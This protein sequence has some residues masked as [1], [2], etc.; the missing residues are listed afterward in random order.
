MSTFALSGN[1]DKN[2]V[3]II[4]RSELE[5]RM[6]P[7][8]Y[9]PEYLELE[10]SL[11]KANAVPLRKYVRGIAGGATPK[12]DEY[13]KYYAGKDTGIPF[14]R[15]QN[16]STTSIL[17]YDDCKYINK[18]THNGMLKRSK[19]KEGDLLVK[20]TG[21]GRMAIASVAPKGFVGNINQHIAVIKTDDEKT[22]KVLAAWLNTDMAEKLA[23]RRSTR[24]TRPA[25]DYPALLSIPVI[26]DEKI[27]ELMN[28][29][30]LQMKQKQQQAQELLES[31]DAYLLNELGITLPQTDDLLTNR[32]FTVKFSEVTGGRLDPK[33]Y[34]FDSKKLK[35]SILTSVYE[36]KTL[37]DFIIQSISGEWGLDEVDSDSHY[38]KCLV[39]R[40]TEFDNDF[41]LDLDN[42][43]MK[44]RFILKSK[45]AKIDLKENDLLIEKSGGSEDQPVGRV[46]LITTEIINSGNICFSNFIHKIRVGNILPEYLFCYL[47][48]AH[49]IK[50]TDTMQ[51]QTNGLRNLIMSNYFNQP[52]PFPPLEKQKEIANHISAILTQAKQ[53]QQQAEKTLQD[54]TQ[55]IEK[56]ILK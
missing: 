7:F 53:L 37:N 1:V 6:D 24:G 11:K 25:L 28:D 42:S 22:S 43:R 33:L 36:I 31:I 29:S 17:N 3:F 50:F 19:V 35:K 49:R 27:L 45:L 41:N 51:S 8:F 44:Y 54:A 38:E 55:Q 39:I 5:G 16:L 34:S 10:K 26:Y 20:I 14:L 18:E 2:K 40:A 9:K 15:V 21:V 13:E 47:K 4:K 46:A 32:M 56:M 12:T 23:K 30:V 48:M 52:I